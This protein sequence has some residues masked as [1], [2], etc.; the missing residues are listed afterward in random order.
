MEREV[1]DRGKIDLLFEEA[2]VN[3]LAIGRTADEQVRGMEG[4]VRHARTANPDMDIVMMHFACPIKVEDYNQGKTPEVIASHESVAE[5]YGVASLDLTL[6]VTERI[7]RGE[8]TWKDDFKSLH[9][10]PF[11]QKLY[12]ASIARL[13]D[14]AWA[15][16]PVPGVIV[17]AGGREVARS[18][19]DG[20][21]EIR[22]RRA[23]GEIEME[24]E[25]WH[26][27][28][29]KELREGRLKGY[30]CPVLVWMARD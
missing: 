4:I 11:G 21:A 6:E 19:A 18:D 23:P 13:W 2:A 24:L 27:V 20:L 26:V 16:A 30:A 3:D 9:P 25:G 29:S 12:A 8:F 10:S 14:A 22:A 15:A 28:G 5:H 17:R 7:N 1:L